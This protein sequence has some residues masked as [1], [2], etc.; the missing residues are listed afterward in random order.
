MGLTLSVHVRFKEVPIERDVDVDVVAVDRILALAFV[1]THPHLV[2]ELEGQQDALALHD[3]VL[4]RLGVHQ[5]ALLLILH[6]VHV[7]LLEVPRVHVHIED[8]DAWHAAPELARE[9][10]EMSRHVDEDS[11]KQKHLIGVCAVEGFASTHREHRVLCLAWSSR[12]SGF[13]FGAFGAFRTLCSRR[14]FQTRLSWRSLFSL[15]SFIT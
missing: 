9:H 13:T 1:Q 11:V 8:V 2:V 7:G 15:F 14:T 6:D 10:V 5:S 3:G 12:G 4:S